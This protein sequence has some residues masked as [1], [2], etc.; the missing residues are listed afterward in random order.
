MA[1]LAL[2]G[3]KAE[4]GEQRVQKVKTEMDQRRCGGREKLTMEIA[5]VWKVMAEADLQNCMK[6][7]D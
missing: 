4:E 3:E 1:L 6:A 2:W 7:I 5:E